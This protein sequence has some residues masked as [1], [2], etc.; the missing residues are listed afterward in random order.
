MVAGVYRA[1]S[2]SP[3]TTTMS[4]VVFERPSLVALAERPVPAARDPHDVV[5]RIEATGICGTDRGIVNGQFPASSGVILGH[6]AVGTVHALGD[7]VN[8]VEPGDRVIINPTYYC[9]RC[10]PC[11]RGMPA[12][13][14]A[15]DGR[16]I[17]V[18]CDGTMTRF[19]V[20]PERFVHPID[21]ATPTRQAI[22]VEPLAC[23]LNNLA[24][25]H[26]RP[27]DR[28]L[29]SGA[30]PVGVLCALVLAERHARV[31]IVDRDRTR[32]EL[33][34]ALLPRSVV[35]AELVSGR[36]TDIA[37][38]GVVARPD[39]VVD[40]TGTLLEDAVSIVAEGGTVVL[41]GEREDAAATLRL[42]PVVTRGIRI[43]GA[44]SYPPQ[45]FELALEL[46]G[47]CR[48]K[49]WS[50]T[51][52]RSSATRMHSVC[53]ASRSRA[54]AR[55]CPSEATERPATGR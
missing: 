2:D 22:M 28:I 19:A 26:P 51:R 38:A 29:V 34:R 48:W 6:E 35:V 42:R 55:N 12:H 50:R 47:S 52:S 15:K 14:Q 20:A 5:I 13:C 46:S 43:V 30:G 21:P 16:E 39:V 32:I 25:A 23:V 9:G 11:R 45:T 7:R 37:Q 31:N 17:G 18:D 41:M 36:L 4:A 44:G 33:A 27:D 53:S 24:A 10:R 1:R 3:Q 40:T 49:H 8:L 54:Q